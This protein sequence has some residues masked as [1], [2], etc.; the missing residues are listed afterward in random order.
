MRHALEHLA[1]G[2][3]ALGLHVAHDEAEAGVADLT[4]VLAL[5]RAEVAPDL[6]GAVDGSTCTTNWFAQ[7]GFRRVKFQINREALLNRLAVA[8]RVGDGIELVSWVV[9]ILQFGVGAVICRVLAISR[10]PCLAVVPARRCAAVVNPS[11][12]LGHWGIVGHL[13][14]RLIVRVSDLPAQCLIVGQLRFGNSLV[15]AATL[16]VLALDA[17]HHAGLARQAAHGVGPGVAQL[18]LQLRFVEPWQVLATPFLSTVLGQHA[19]VNQLVG[20]AVH[21]IADHGGQSD[22]MGWRDNAGLEFLFHQVADHG[23]LGLAQFGGFPGDGDGGFLSFLDVDL[24]LAQLAAQFRC[25]GFHAQSN[26]DRAGGF[27]QLV[28]QPLT[29]GELQAAGLVAPWV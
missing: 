23:A 26:Q 2:D 9:D 11:H 25:G 4:H 16:E 15:Q 5:G 28:V 8:V 19:Q 12:T 17:L 20:L 1:Q 27:A 10:K 13:Q 3:V 6:H 22:G 24:H 18:V 29:R 14:R 21:G 7:A